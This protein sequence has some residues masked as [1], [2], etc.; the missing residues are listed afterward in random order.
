MQNLFLVPASD[1]NLKATIKKAVPFSRVQGIIPA[2]TL[3]QLKQGFF[4]TPRSL[5]GGG[6]PSIAISIPIDR[7]LY[8]FNPFS[9]GQ[10]GFLN[11]E[12]K[13]FCGGLCVFQRIVMIEG[14]IKMS[15]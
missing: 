2:R 9:R 10:T 4:I 1:S 14:N 11:S 8:S 13:Y 15:T 5:A 12:G 3:D 6:S 7:K